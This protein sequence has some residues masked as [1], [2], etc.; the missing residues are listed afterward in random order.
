M[1][2]T[3]NTHGKMRT[4]FIYLFVVYL[5]TPFQLFKV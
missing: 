3:C 1:G 4:V 5:T 2:G